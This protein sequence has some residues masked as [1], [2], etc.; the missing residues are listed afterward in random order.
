[1]RNSRQS[2]R[3]DHQVSAA[4]SGILDSKPPLFWTV[5]W[6]VSCYVIDLKRLVPKKGFDLPSFSNS[7]SLNKLAL[8][9]DYTGFANFSILPITLTASAVAIELHELRTPNRIAVSNCGHHGLIRRPT[10]NPAVLARIPC[11]NSEQPH[12][13]KVQERS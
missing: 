2:A 10:N 12:K 13:R 3:P 8:I 7:F 6:T 4:R 5:R 1:M 11:E 9:L